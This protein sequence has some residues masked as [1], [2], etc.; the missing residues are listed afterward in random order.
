MRKVVLMVVG[1]LALS[2]CAAFGGGSDPNDNVITNEEIQAAAALLWS[3]INR[4]G[5]CA[6]AEPR[7]GGAPAGDRQYGRVRRACA[8]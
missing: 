2:G 3:Q 5:L 6:L 4:G 7:P 8:A 1:C